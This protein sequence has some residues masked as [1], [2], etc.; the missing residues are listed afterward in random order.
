MAMR[1][2]LRVGLLGG[3]E[4]A[5]VAED[6]LRRGGRGDCGGIGEELCVGEGYDDAGDS[7][8]GGGVWN[9]DVDVV[10]A[11]FGVVGAGKFEDVTVAEHGD[12]ILEIA[13]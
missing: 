8:E 2:A 6:Y 10:Q 13:L 3:M 4:R 5:M 12:Y 9:G 1:T 11:G 7:D